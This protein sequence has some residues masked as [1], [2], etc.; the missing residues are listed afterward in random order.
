MVNHYDFCTTYVRDLFVGHFWRHSAKY[1]DVLMPVQ[2]CAIDINEIS[3]ITFIR[4][5]VKGTQWW[6]RRLFRHERGTGPKEVEAPSCG[7]KQ[8]C[9]WRM[10]WHG[11]CYVKAVKINPIKS[12]HNHLRTFPL[13][14]AYQSRVV[15]PSQAKCANRRGDMIANDHAWVNKPLPCYT[16]FGD[17][18][19]RWT[20]L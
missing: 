5:T 12:K 1:P 16:G 20:F 9:G 4:P 8:G 15:W 18:H 19:R 10:G 11:V 3:H 7:G 17:Q 2:V 14:V 13:E 6:S